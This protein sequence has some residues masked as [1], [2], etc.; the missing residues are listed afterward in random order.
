[1]HKDEGEVVRGRR[2][3]DDTTSVN[4]TPV[5]EEPPSCVMS[6]IG[7]ARVVGVDGYMGGRRRYMYVGSASN[8]RKLVEFFFSKTMKCYIDIQNKQMTCLRTI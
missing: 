8:G 3:G 2:G 1:M 7:G 5:R 4:L 6:E